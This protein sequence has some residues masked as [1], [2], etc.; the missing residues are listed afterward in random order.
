M[1]VRSVLCSWVHPASLNVCVLFLKKNLWRFTE[2]RCSVSVSIAQAGGTSPESA[3]KPDRY[4]SPRPLT[5]CSSPLRASLLLT[6]ALKASKSA[7]ER[8]WNV[9]SRLLISHTRWRTNKSRNHTWKCTRCLCSCWISFA[10]NE[11]VCI[12]D[13]LSSRGAERNV[14]PVFNPTCVRLPPPPRCKQ[15]V[16]YV[17]RCSPRVGHRHVRP[18]ASSEPRWWRRVPL[19][20]V[21][22]RALRR[23][24]V[25]EYESPP[26]QKQHTHRWQL[27]VRHRAAHLHNVLTSCPRGFFFVYLIHVCRREKA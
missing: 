19:M 25:S 9:L 21:V 3:I 6:R 12:H 2:T 22:L 5:Q 20:M 13:Q 17:C 16:D 7:E 10:I 27:S 8:K 15:P 26:V 24:A 14:A 11:I 18:P 4:T 1:S 23:P